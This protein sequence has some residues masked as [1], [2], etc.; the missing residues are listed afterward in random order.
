MGEES[1][2]STQHIDFVDCSEP[3]LSALDPV[4]TSCIWYISV[5]HHQAACVLPLHNHINGRSGLLSVHHL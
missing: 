4:P 2:S 3:S 5:F 1:C